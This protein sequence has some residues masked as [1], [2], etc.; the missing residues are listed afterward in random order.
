MCS[1]LALHQEVE[2]GKCEK[3]KKTEK[4]NILMKINLLL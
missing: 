4:L 1:L 2:M 3:E